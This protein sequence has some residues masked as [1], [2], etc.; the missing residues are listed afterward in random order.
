MRVYAL[1][2]AR[3]VPTT[4]PMTEVD[5]S[6]PNLWLGTTTYPSALTRA[7]SEAG[8]AAFVTEYAGPPPAVAI[9][10]AS[11]EDL[12]GEADPDAFVDA[13]VRRGYTTDA[14]YPAISQRFLAA[15]V[16]FAPSAFVDALNEGIA[17]PRLRAEQ[18]LAQH[19]KLTR[20][21]TTMTA[22]QMTVDP[23]FELTAALP[24]VDN[25]HTAT[26]VTKCSD[27]YFESEAPRVIELADGREIPVSPGTPFEGSDEDFCG[28]AVARRLGGGGGCAIASARAASAS[29]L[30]AVLAAVAVVTI[31]RRKTRGRNRR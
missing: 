12:R 19:A 26:F 13:L 1:G 6:D 22:A 23:I 28:G 30:G 27:R 5:F 7:I 25:V 10:L 24:D 16:P 14:R 21:S 29:M 31:R 18:T 15:G 8:G 4:H 17:D 9:A 20:L 11:I 2:S 3:A